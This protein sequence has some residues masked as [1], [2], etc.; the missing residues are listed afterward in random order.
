MD[1]LLQTKDR[2]IR[3]LQDKL[4]AKD[5]RIKELEKVA[6]KL[7]SRV[8]EILVHL[9]QE[10]Q[11]RVDRYRNL[12]TVFDEEQR[13]MNEMQ[14]AI[15]EKDEQLIEAGEKVAELQSQIDELQQDLE[16]VRKDHK[17]KAE[18]LNIVLAKERRMKA[19][20]GLDED[21]SEQEVLEHLQ[22]SFHTRSELKKAQDELGK[23]TRE[24]MALDS[25]IK[26]LTHEKDSI[27]FEIRQKELE[28]KRM[29]GSHMASALPRR[30]RDPY[31]RVT[32]RQTGLSER[33]KTVPRIDVNALP[34]LPEP[35]SVMPSMSNRSNLSTARV[36]TAFTQE[37]H[38]PMLQ[39]RR[40]FA[41]IVDRETK[42]CVICRKNY[43]LKSEC[44]IHV[45]PIISGKFSCCGA[46]AYNAKYV[47]CKA[48]NHLYIYFSGIGNEYTFYDD[49]G[50]PLDF[51]V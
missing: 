18:E 45:E 35:V 9:Q 29:R 21:A 30:I 5:R 47:G 3:D 23:I 26:S 22:K 16:C 14:E 24:K 10:M 6:D 4:V 41:N 44:R 39:R 27:E 49:R 17:T 37:S 25:S 34:R 1:L 32:R 31:A 7:K 48:V 43:Y 8:D 15:N 28:V 13:I 40:T 2:Q 19:N 50:R 33:T 11:N 20:L 38:P 36:S 42:Y 12:D 51:K 46:D